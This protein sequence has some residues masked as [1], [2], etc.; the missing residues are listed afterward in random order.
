MGRRAL[1]A[2][3]ASLVLVGVMFVTLFPT[4]AYLHQRRSL[5]HVSS[6]LTVLRRQNA[7]LAAR[8]AKLETDAEVARLA[9]TDYGLVSPGEEAYA[10]LPSG[11]ASK[12]PGGAVRARAGGR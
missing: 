5:D 7:A 11:R 2:V 6:Q 3:V 9:R 12:A 10:I 4:G 1:W 8:A